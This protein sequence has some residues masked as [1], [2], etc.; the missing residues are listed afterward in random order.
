MSFAIR[1]R[2]L[3][4]QYDGRPPVEAV[5]GVDLE[6]R[7]GECFG[8]L[9][10]NGAGKT[11]TMEILEGLLPATSADLMEVLGL[12]WGRDDMAIRRRIG[13]SLQETR[14]TDKLTVLETVV[15][16]RSFYSA[17]LDPA[18][19][20]RRVSLD[21]KQGALIEKL[22]GG[23]KQR[24]AVACGIVADPE[25]LFLDEPTTGLD[26]HSRR[27]LWDIVREF[28]SSGRTI[29][30]TTHYMDEAERLCDRVAVIDQGQV[31]ALGTPV[32]LIA[33]L[34]GQHIVD[35][36][37]TENSHPFTDD[38]LRGMASVQSVRREENTISLSVG[39]PHV[40]LPA[41]MNHVQETGREF[42]TL[43]TRHAT[44]EDV[45]VTLT[46]RHLRDEGTSK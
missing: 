12:S 46:G 45:F 42:A 5:R 7:S 20:I 10:P 32:E 26:P 8:L 2:N 39:E 30:L 13:I 11:T 27:E 35:F 31:I 24:L 37:L 33:R 34:G 22:S 1:C 25:L 38:D 15:L 23:Q 43:T 41:L 18:E 36:S 28:R 19:A 4:K 14:L 44:L 40:A 17:G 16:F 21:D 9:G 3:V 6:V 29:L